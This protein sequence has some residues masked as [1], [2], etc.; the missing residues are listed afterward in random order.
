ML[1]KLQY[2]RERP[3]PE[4]DLATPSRAALGV[5]ED[6][7]RCLPEGSVTRKPSIGSDGMGGAQIIWRFKKTH[8]LISA[9]AGG[10]TIVPDV[11]MF[12]RKDGVRQPTLRFDTSREYADNILVHLSLLES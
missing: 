7:V 9:S 5:L 3:L 4:G 6:I 1:E 12:F 8:L 2:L 11:Y 10:G